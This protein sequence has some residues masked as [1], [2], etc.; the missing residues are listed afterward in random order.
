M[1]PSLL[2]LKYQIKGPTSGIS[3]ASSSG[4]ISIGDSYRLI[5][6]GYSDIMIAGGVDFNLNRHFFEG[7]ELFG[8]NCNEF[9]EDPEH[10]SKPFD[11]NRC[12]PALSDGGGALIL[13]SLESAMKR[14]AKIYCEIIGY[15]Q[16]AD[17]YHILRPS[18]NG[19]GLYKAIK[20]AMVEAQITPSMID[21]F[22][23]HATSTKA[24]DLGEA[25]CIKWLI[26]NK[27]I[28]D[29]LEKFKASSV[30]EDL[31]CKD[32]D[33]NNMKRSVITA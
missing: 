2:S 8:A 23:A 4:A 7:M 17:A 25:N 18:E 5:K 27:D 29:N 13:E 21:N 10:G 26:G 28:W 16:N 3:M 32:L 9:N 31:S 14:K 30:E 24:G 33:L 22:N 6:H 11:K 19:F 20:E 15:S 12:G 1:V